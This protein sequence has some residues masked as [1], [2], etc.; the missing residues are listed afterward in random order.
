MEWLTKFK[1]AIDYIEEHLE[2][3]ILSETLAGIAGCSKYDFGRLFSYITGISPSEYIRQRRMT[4][5]CF[6]LQTGEDKVI[7]IG[8]KYG[9]DTP[10]SFNRAFQSVHG[11]PPSKVK[12]EGIKLKAYPKLTL[13]I[14]ASA[15]ETLRYRI[16]T[17][18][19]LSIVGLSMPLTDNMK[20]NMEN[21]PHFWKAVLEKDQFKEL[22]KL[23][24][25]DNNLQGILGVSS[26]GESGHLQ[27]T[28]A[29]ASNCAALKGFNRLVIP[30]SIWV[31]F[32]LEGSF[33]ESIQKIYKS[34]FT[35]WLP[36]SGYELAG[37]A[38]IEVYPVETQGKNS[39]KAEVWFT[40][41]KTN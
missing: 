23:D 32:E 11:V 41:K 1:E 9:Y 3:E 28:I 29:R 4:K 30:P 12:N 14:K 31:V 22:L 33:P 27:Y 10:A 25:E 38:D 26:Y 37:I 17:K 36:F 39:G 24:T 16:V 5:A 2:D 13:S 19:A 7:N 35:E 8:A 18:K 20:E 6:R 34:F 40:I 21:I 15:S